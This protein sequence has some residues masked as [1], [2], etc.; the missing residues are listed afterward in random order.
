MAAHR[1]EGVPDRAK[2]PKPLVIGEA[3]LCLTIVRYML[4]FVVSLY[5]EADGLET[6]S[7]K[8]FSTVFP[9]AMILLAASSAVG[10]ASA[11][12][13]SWRKVVR[14]SLLLLAVNTSYSV[15]NGMGISLGGVVFDN[16][17]ILVLTVLTVGLMFL[18]SVRRYYLPPLTE[19]PPLRSWI[20]YVFT[21]RLFPEAT[22]S[23]VTEEDPS[24]RTTSE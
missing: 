22:Y 6:L 10:I 13:K 20:G 14:T 5:T 16:A 12:P 21:T 9:F 18:P 17:F 15:L 24:E 8:L 23:F 7:L 3:F 4:N 1:K 19:D 11:R 2:V